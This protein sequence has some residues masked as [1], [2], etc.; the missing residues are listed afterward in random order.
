MEE[1]KNGIITKLKAKLEMDLSCDELAKLAE[2]YATLERDSW[3]KELSKTVV[4]TPS[5]DGFGSAELADVNS[6]S[7]I[8]V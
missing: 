3:M 1:L 7:Q 2:A 8:L 4:S 5:F 6:V